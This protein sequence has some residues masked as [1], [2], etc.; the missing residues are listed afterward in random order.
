MLHTCPAGLVNHSPKKVG[1]KPLK[2]QQ[3]SETS[4]DFRK[5][6]VRNSASRF[7]VAFPPIEALQLVNQD[8]AGYSQAGWKLDLE[9]IT[10]DVARHRTDKREAGLRVV[11]GR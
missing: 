7:R 2:P 6:F 10:L 5:E 9:R 4:E 3:R 1:R 11:S 8:H